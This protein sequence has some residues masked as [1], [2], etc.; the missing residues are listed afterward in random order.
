MLTCSQRCLNIQ[1]DTGMCPWGRIGCELLAR[2]RKLE[3]GFGTFISEN[4]S[5]NHRL[6]WLG[7][8]LQD[9]PVPSTQTGRD[10]FHWIPPVSIKMLALAEELLPFPVPAPC[11]SSQHWISPGLGHPKARTPHPFPRW[12][13]GWEWSSWWIRGRVLQPEPKAGRH[14]GASRCSSGCFLPSRLCIVIHKLWTA[15]EFL[16]EQLHEEMN[17]GW[18][19]TANKAGNEIKT[20]AGL[21]F[22]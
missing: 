4:Q 6:V 7:S 18:T 2:E 21:G 10:T 11:S 14:P 22:F 1:Q 12:K 13:K 20:D 5:W 3:K 15:L 16:F 8:D 9:P 19:Q 17:F